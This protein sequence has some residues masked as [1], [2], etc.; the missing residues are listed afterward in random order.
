LE[1][2]PDFHQVSEISAFFDQLSKFHQ[3]FTRFSP[4]LCFAFNFT[5]KTDKF[6]QKNWKN[7]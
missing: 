3:V 5:A 1:I 6:H 2:S 7:P 4:G